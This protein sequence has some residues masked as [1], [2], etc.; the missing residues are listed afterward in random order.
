MSPMLLWS[1]YTRQRCGKYEFTFFIHTN[2]ALNDLCWQ[3]L[4]SSLDSAMAVSMLMVAG[5]FGAVVGSNVSSI[6]LDSYCEYTFYVPG[7]LF[8]GK[9]RILSMNS[10]VFSSILRNLLFQ[11][12][13]WTFLHFRSTHEKLT[14]FMHPI[15][16]IFCK[17]LFLA[18]A[19]LVYLIPYQENQANKAK[20]RRTIDPRASVISYR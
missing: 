5:R 12:V 2:V 8:G 6:L 16:Y 17:L 20:P 18:A 15:D 7:C 9:F 19:F 1:I 11:W 3:I 13:Q 4:F 10:H 14:N